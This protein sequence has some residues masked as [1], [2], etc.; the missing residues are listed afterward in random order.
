MNASR[1]N[2]I[3]RWAGF[4]FAAACV[5]FAVGQDGTLSHAQQSLS[6]W[7]LGKAAGQGSYVGQGECA[8]CHAKIA[9]R[10]AQSGMARALA[11][12]G[13]CE[14]LRAY[15]PFAF[16]LH[17]FTYRIERLGEQFNYTVSRGNE[18]VTTPLLWCFGH[19]ASGHTFVVRHESVYYETRV[20][21]FTQLAGLD[22]TPGAPRE[23]PASVKAA[24]GQPQRHAEM[25]GCFTCHSTP[26][27]GTFVVTLEQFTPGLHCE[28]CHGPGSAHVAQAA[29][30]TLTKAGNARRVK[31][32]IF[33]P[34]RWSPDDVNQ[35]F[36]GACHRSWESVMQMP[37]R[38]GEANVRFQPYRL[39]NS[40][41]Y[42]NPD[43][44]RISCIACHDPHAPLSHEA[45]TYD[46]K[47]LACHQSGSVAL[48][49]GRAAPA[50]S[51]GKQQD[52]AACHMPKI[53]PEGLHFKFT[54]H[55]IRI[56]KAGDEYPR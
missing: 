40:K 52:C 2:S 36:C 1:A 24:L 53:E 42:Q 3:K 25:Q 37:D 5:L 15:A 6:Q 30:T 32:T 13:E 31:Q 12:A 35:Q 48:K 39:A 45:A 28:A 54:D 50:C 17:G 49:K 43:D 10:Y 34:S 41:C 22:V 51:A 20:S 29:Q 4:C 18:S 19:G 14:T 11:P 33:N 55:W 27:A 38:G 44:R 26:G 7:K 47:C 8:K 23:A 46:A 16:T 9:A 56:V 21:Y